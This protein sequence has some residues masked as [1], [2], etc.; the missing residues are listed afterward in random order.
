[1]HSTESY[2]STCSTVYPR[3]ILP[4]HLS[5]MAAFVKC[6]S[7]GQ[8]KKVPWLQ[9]NPVFTRHPN[10]TCR[11][12]CVVTEGRTPHCRSSFLTWET[13]SKP[14]TWK[15]LHTQSPVRSHRSRKG[16]ITCS[17]S[18]TILTV[19]VQSA[20]LGW[21]MTQPALIHSFR[22]GR[23]TETGGWR[24]W[25]KKLTGFHGNLIGT[26]AVQTL[27]GNCLCFQFFYCI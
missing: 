18:L 17:W 4:P 16:L 8:C 1:M 9:L 27:L 6:P 12:H 26:E 15:H 22:E 13:P 23:K 21:T 24:G 5:S 11:G 3:K 20:V 10:D 14:I 25:W 7:L 2:V 19:S